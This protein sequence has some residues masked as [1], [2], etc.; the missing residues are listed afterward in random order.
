MTLSSH[1]CSNQSAQQL[2]RRWDLAECLLEASVV[3]TAKPLSSRKE[4]MRE[5]YCVRLIR[6]AARSVV[7]E[8]QVARHLETQVGKLLAHL[9]STSG[10]GL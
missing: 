3:T 6:P 7:L 8:K 9:P 2:L 10:C 5:A 1:K 4:H